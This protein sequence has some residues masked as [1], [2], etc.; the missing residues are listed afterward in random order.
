MFLRLA[1][2][3]FE[4]L[5]I[6]VAAW[7]VGAT[8]LFPIR[9]AAR[10]LGPAASVAEALTGRGFHFAAVGIGLF[11]VLT[12]NVA[13]GYWSAVSQESVWRKIG[14]VLRRRR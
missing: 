7:C 8:L 1:R 5:A 11:A 14:R 12:A 4:L 2:L 9:F 13:L 10:R 6:G 3:R